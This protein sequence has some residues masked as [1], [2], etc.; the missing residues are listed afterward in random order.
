[1]GLYEENIIGDKVKRAALTGVLGSFA[2]VGLAAC[3][4]AIATTAP[5]PSDSIPCRPRHWRQ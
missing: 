1:M 4:G 5:A 3:G 2:V